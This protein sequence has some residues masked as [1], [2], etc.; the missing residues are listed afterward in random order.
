MN[1]DLIAF[2]L[3][4]ISLICVCLSFYHI[5][6]VIKD[7]KEIEKYLKMNNSICKIFGHEYI[8]VTETKVIEFLWKKEE[9]TKTICKHCK[10][11]KET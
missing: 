1:W 8:Q 4:I 9:I 10:K 6:Q 2:I 11:Q 7:F 5:Y 3:N